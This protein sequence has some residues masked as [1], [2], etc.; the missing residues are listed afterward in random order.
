MDRM[1]VRPILAIK[2]SVTIDTMLKF[3]GDFH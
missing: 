1:G 3:D 2:M